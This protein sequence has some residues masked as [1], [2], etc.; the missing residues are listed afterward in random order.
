[1]KFIKTPLSGAYIIET[2]KR[3]DDRGFFART[4]DRS[5]FK[6]HGVKTDFVQSSMSYTKQRGTLRGMHYQK[7]PND[8]GK[9]MYITKGRIYD[10][11]IDLRKNS[12]TYK[13]WFSTELS[14]DSCKGL[15]IPEGFAHGFITLTSD[16][17]VRYMMTAFYK[18][19][20]RAGVRYDDPAFGIRWPIEITKISEKDAHFPN[21]DS[22]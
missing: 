19:E 11:I 20:S 6:T 12:A 1:M 22:R 13:K 4:W 15:Y 17:E 16:V 7:S 18:Q 5:E 10:V 21:Y 9:L 3:E 8:E 14:D 2:E